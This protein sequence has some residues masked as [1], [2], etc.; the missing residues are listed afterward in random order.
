MKKIVM[1]GG[2]SLLSMGVYAQEI[3]HKRCA[4]V[5]YTNYL[6]SKEPGYIQKTEK[7]F[8]AARDKSQNAQLKL[9]STYT[10]PVVVHVVYNTATENIA[11]SVIHN[12]I[13]VLNEDYNRENADSV[14]LRSEFFPHVG[15]GK[16]R[17]QLAAVDP[18]GNLTTGIT[19]TQSTVTSFMDL[20]GFMGGDMS[21]T[22]R[23][24]STAD[25]GKDPWDQTKYLNI[26]VCD[27][28]VD[29]L[30][31]EMQM[32]MG[33][34]T[35]PANLP[36]WPAGSTSGMSDGVVIQYHVF[37]RNN[38]N[39]L[40][41]DGVAQVVKG[42]T[43][44][45]EVGHYLGLRHIWGDDASCSVDDG[46]SDT[47]NANDKSNFDCNKTKNTCT[48]DNI[49][50][51][52]LPDMVENFMD[53]SAE[54]CQNTFTD[55]QIQLMRA[56]LED[57]REDLINNNPALG[58]TENGTLS[59][60]ISP[61]PTKSSIE[62]KTRSK[63]E[64]SLQLFDLNGKQVLSSHATGNQTTI[65]LSNLNNGVYQ[66]VLTHKDGSRAVERVVKN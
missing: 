60:T 9:Q 28:S 45:H 35:P 46:V 27:M 55:G 40:L 38:P 61:N 63:F 17:F 62:V 14:N 29:F 43:V 20:M 51:V 57:H 3:Q 56:V 37:G 34:A 4:T 41:V 23:V 65:D 31:Q 24:K 21:S 39:P 44:T 15:R 59:L 50:G 5:E 13:Q 54:D 32:L 49:G 42:R 33:Y 48:N 2:F 1:L 10:I 8:N 64:G 19:R 30:G 7:A 6:E 22:E 66:L 11:D 26:W 25:G 16:I 58:I 53:Y 47:P 36:N 18:N 12:Q 52:D